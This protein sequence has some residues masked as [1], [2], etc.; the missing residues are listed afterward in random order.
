MEKSYVD[1]WI[2]IISIAVG[3]VGLLINADEFR[4]TKEIGTFLFGVGVGGLFCI[5][6]VAR[7]LNKSRG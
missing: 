7:A 5:L 3:A 6:I 2:F 1:F 4:D